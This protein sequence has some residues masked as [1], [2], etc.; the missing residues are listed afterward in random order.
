M[1]RD[2]DGRGVGAQ[3]W[4]IYARVREIDS[5]LRSSQKLRERLYESHPE[6]CFRALSG[7]RSMIYSKHSREGLDERRSLIDQYFG[8]D[9]FAQ[10]RSAYPKTQ[11][12][13]DDILDAYA[14]CWTA[15]R[16]LTSEAASLPEHPS[17]DT[18][19]LPMR[20]VY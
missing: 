20:I 7:G 9:S 19:G 18:L 6:L 5:L 8:V 14:V 15:T 10:V 2:A 11:V 12:S 4:N 13:D 1:T 16:I 3:A 17:L